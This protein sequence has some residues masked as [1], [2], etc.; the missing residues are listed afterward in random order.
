MLQNRRGQA[1]AVSRCAG[2]LARNFDRFPTSGISET[3]TAR[4]VEARARSEAGGLA[5]AALS[6]A[7]ALLGSRVME[8]RGA[9]HGGIRC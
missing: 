3:A 8:L 5:A 9:A 4:A 6:L 7:K 2:S 1:D